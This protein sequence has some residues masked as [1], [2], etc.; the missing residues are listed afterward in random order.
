MR[1]I[2]KYLFQEK[3][4][5]N[6]EIKENIEEEKIENFNHHNRVKRRYGL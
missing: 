4:N 5:N 3:Q 6:N 1:R 2:M